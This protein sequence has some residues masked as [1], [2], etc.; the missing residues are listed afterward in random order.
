MNQDPTI[1]WVKRWDFAM[2]SLI[3]LVKYD[4]LRA[5]REL[6]R[7]LMKAA[8]SLVELRIVGSTSDVLRTSDGELWMKTPDGDELCLELTRRYG[9]DWRAA[10]YY[11][12]IK[13]R[14]WWTGEI[15]RHGDKA[16]FD[17]EKQQYGQ[18]SIGIVQR[19]LWENHEVFVE[20]EVILRLAIKFGAMKKWVIAYSEI[21]LNEKHVADLMVYILS[22]SEWELDP[23]WTRSYVPT[24]DEIAR[25]AA[26]CR[27]KNP[28]LPG[29][30]ASDLDG[31]LF[32]QGGLGSV[33]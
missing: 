26:E 23:S 14:E 28:R 6:T 32:G 20:P 21:M 22:L 8:R 29:E 15:C 33:D 16:I 24:L 25:G 2:T 12:L 19:Q 30:M 4:H 9:R 31:G 3:S 10:C 13:L 7:R 11:R 27:E 18:V 1:K 17:E 5:R